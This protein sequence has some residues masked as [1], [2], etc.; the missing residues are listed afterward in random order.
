MI[1]AQHKPFTS[2]ENG[3]DDGANSNVERK[4]TGRNDF[5]IGWSVDCF[6]VETLID[7][8]MLSI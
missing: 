7:E 1:L 4:S 5:N 6:W 3:N 8:P 2:Y